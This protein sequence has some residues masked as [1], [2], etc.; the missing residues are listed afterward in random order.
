MEGGAS[1]INAAGDSH[2]AAEWT[3]QLHQ[4]N[5]DKRKVVIR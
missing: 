4:P 1:N 2:Y 3:P 5:T